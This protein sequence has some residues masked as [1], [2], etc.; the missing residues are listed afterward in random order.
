MVT[1]LTLLHRN[2]QLLMRHTLHGCV[3]AVLLIMMAC[4]H[5]AAPLFK[6]RLKPKLIT[7]IALNDRHVQCT[8]SEDI[9]TL[10]LQPDFFSI[11]TGEDTLK[12]L[13]V[14]PSLS[15]SE[16]IVVTAPQ[17]STVYDFSGYVY[18]QNENMGTFTSSFTGTSLPDT[19]R[20]WIVQ[21]SQGGKT[22]RFRLFFSEM[23]DTSFLKCYTAPHIDLTAT[24]TNVRTCRLQP[25]SGALYHDTT[26]YLLLVDGARDITGNAIEPFVTSITPDTAYRPLMLKGTAMVN[27][28]LAQDGLAVLYRN[29]P[30]GFA[31]VENGS[32]IF[33]VRD[34]ALF[35]VE[36]IAGPYAGKD[37]V[38]VGDENI[39]ILEPQEKNIDSIIH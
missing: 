38:A 30:V 27:D 5:K 15:A 32:F 18:D 8:F 1:V 11:T 33:E 7:T 26:Y 25:D 3:Y 35:S 31:L 39:I 9:D 34:S 23:M 13:A 29:A 21:Y 2:I 14:Y 37:E 17:S 20:P 12:I 28:T 4:A 10:N 16:I 19:L 6:D 24:W 36:V 22:E